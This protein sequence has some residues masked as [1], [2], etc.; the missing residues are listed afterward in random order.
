M[1]QMIS[2]NPNIPCQ[3][4]WC[5][6]YV[7][8]A[9][10]VPKRFGTATAAWQASTT[11]HRDRD[12]P[13]GVWLPVWYGLANEPAGH[14]VLRA[15]DGSC[16]STSD[17]TNTPYH[18]PDLAHLE[19]FYAYYGMTLTYRGWTED[20]EGTAV[21]SPD[22]DGINY[23]GSI[24]PTQEEPDMAL[25]ETDRQKFYEFLDGY[26]KYEKPFPG[27]RTFI[28]N[29]KRVAEDLALISGKIDKLPQTILFDTRVDGRNQ[30]DWDKYNAAL[31]I[32]N[33]ANTANGAA[34]DVEALADA[35]AARLPKTDTKALLDALAVRLAA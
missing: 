12:F 27:D 33:G 21:I 5:L 7:N 8:E 14:V 18:H 24:T 22:A 30:F 34:V 2:P 31:E 26:F 29:E 10:G 23:S 32:A 13:A 35:L 6:A 19:A 4:G 20:V 17:L 9:F 1:R 28:Q 3:P 16:Y 15:P 25:E 11:Q